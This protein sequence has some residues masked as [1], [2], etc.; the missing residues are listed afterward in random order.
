M[1]CQRLLLK[2]EYRFVTI[3][4]FKIISATEED[5]QDYGSFLLKE[6]MDADILHQCEY[7]I[8]SENDFADCINGSMDA[9]EERK[10]EKE[11]DLEGVREENE[12]KGEEILWHVKADRNR[13]YSLLFYGD[14]YHLYKYNFDTTNNRWY[15]EDDYSDS[16]CIRLF[17]KAIMC[18][19]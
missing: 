15:F 19:G 2:K 11:Y 9:E 13:R 8:L 6:C 16:N 3:D 14:R 1:Y 5:Y 18:Y 12:G 10:R 4:D 17:K 7:C